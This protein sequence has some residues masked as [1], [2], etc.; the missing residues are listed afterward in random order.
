MKKKL[1]MDEGRQTTAE[2]LIRNVLRYMEKDAK[3][4]MTHRKNIEAI[5]EDEKLE[6][7]IKI[8]LNDNYSRYPVYTEDIDQI[9]GFMHLKDAMECYINEEF[10]QMPLKELK[11]YIRP[12]AFIPETKNIDRL[13]K[14]MQQEKNH[15]V[16]VMDEYGQTSGL[17]SLEDILE[18]IVGNIMD[19]H[20]VEEEQVESFP[21]GTYIVSGM[22]ELEKVGDLIPIIFDTSE[23]ETVNGFMIDQ[24]DRIPG[25]D[26]SCVVEYEGYQ[27]SVLEINDNRIQ[28]VKIEKLA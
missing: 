15:I 14:E 1:I 6:D 4:I 26:E 2:K 18:E 10:R 27:F 9:I 5:N 24:L 19:E 17:V 22:L 16:I 13:F 11:D 3:D 8:M 20:D 21:D 7:A 23:Y 12:V 28:R 25:E